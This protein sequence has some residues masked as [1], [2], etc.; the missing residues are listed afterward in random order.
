MKK[1]K[2]IIISL[3]LSASLLSCGLLVGCKDK[4]KTIT[5]YASLVPHAVIL[6]EYVKPLLEKQGYTLKVKSPAEWQEYNNMLSAGD[7]DAN[8]FQHLPYL[9]SFN[10]KV[11]LKATCKVHYEPLGIYYGKTKKTSYKEGSFEICNDTSNAIRAILL[12][13]DK[14]VIS[15]ETE[16]ENYPISQDGTSFNLEKFKEYKKWT[17]ID[18]KVSISLVP[19][20]LLANSLLDYDFAC[21]PCS[22][23]LTGKISAER[24]LDIEGGEELVAKNAN[25]LAVRENDYIANAEYKAKIDALTDILLSDGLAAFIANKYNGVII[26]DS[27]TQVDLR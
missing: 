26:C 22:T 16:G 5:V 7:C 12:L 9:E 27:I 4:S 24:R 8:Y 3:I 17:S 20:N 6:N 2:N 21:L 11:K 13:T 14:G 18:G 15:K 19:E 25:I 23:A 10:G 1:L